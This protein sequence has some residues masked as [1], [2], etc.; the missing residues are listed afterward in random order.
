[1]TIDELHILNY[2]NI[3]Q[4]DLEF[5][6]KLNCFVGLNGM[7]KTNLLDAIYYL[8]FCKSHSNAI[9]S[10]NIRHGADYFMVQG[11]Y[12][13][14]DESV[15]VTSSL[16]Q[17]QKK[18]FSLNKKEYTK[19]TDHIGLIPLVMISPADMELTEGGS[20]VRRKFV[21]GI[22]SQTDRLYLEHLVQYNM[23]L[24][25]RNALLKSDVQPSDD[26]LEPWEA[27]MVEHAR[28][29]HAKRRDFIE[30]FK[31]V[32]QQYYDTI[33]GHNEQIGLD[34]LSQLDE[35]DI[36][37]MLRDSHQ[38]DYLIGYT[39][40]GTH[41]DELEMTLSGHPIKRIGSQ[42]QNKTYLTALKFAQHELLLNKIGHYPLLL[43]DDLFDRLDQQRVERILQIVGTDK[44]GQIFIT[45][46][47]RSHL[48]L[49]AAQIKLP[50]KMFRVEQGNVI[51]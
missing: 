47:N 40:H 5:S 22:I 15:L 27:Q 3:E 10:Q 43:L 16:K 35:R 9:D 30:E 23:A 25:Q 18:H 8:S 36:A 29:I 41:K 11:R 34:Y 28:Y 26:A 33:S 39:T 31:P 2:K 32:F 12:S 14:G 37:D 17:R 20:E 13:R 46:T 51:P 44:F 49:M 48:D 6:G 24:R 7:G 38:R 45:D 4:A 19:L 50:A 21:D 1:M 42:G